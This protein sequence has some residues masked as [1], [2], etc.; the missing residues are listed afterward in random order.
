MKLHIVPASRGIQW[1]KLGLQTFFKQPLA[2]SGLFFLFI[3]VMSVL[4]MVPLIGAALM[5]V[6]LPGA[7]LG[8]MA[9]TREAAGG[10]FPMPW[11]LLTAF[12]AGRLQLRAMLTLGVLY[13]LGLALL[14]GCTALIDG[15]KFAK[16]YVFGG[17]ATAE[18][19]KQGDLQ[20]AALVAAVLSLPLTQMFWHAPALLYWHGVP[21]VKSLFFSLVAC[22]RN[23]WA[24][25]VFGLAWI[26]IF[27]LF[28]VLMAILVQIFGSADAIAA[29]LYPAVMLMAAMVTTSIYFTFQD[30]FE[31]TPGDDI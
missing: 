3:A 25:T 24:F 17:P 1:V 5:L 30:S 22:L 26:G 29:A 4:G 11:V 8:L 9:A 31:F 15:G 28:I 20:L 23:F 12:R 27:V 14:L 18:M 21:P 13:A 6:L 10:K 2:L 16:L 19:L 7:T